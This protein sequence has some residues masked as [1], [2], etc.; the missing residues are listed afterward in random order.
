[1]SRAQNRPR[2]RPRSEEAKQAILRAARELLAR[3]GPGAVTMEAVA[4]L[5]G[6]GKP[7][8]YRWWPDRHA[9]A[10]AALMETT[11][12]AEQAKTRRS[13]ITELRDQ[14]RA[15]AARFATQTGRH[16]ASMLAAA[17]SASE[18]SKAFRNHFVLARRAEGKLLL[19][20]AVAADLVRDDLDL[21]VALDML[22]GPVFFRL[23]LGHAPLDE[24]FM[25]DVLDEAMRGMAVRR[26]PRKR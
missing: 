21:E 1:M 16:V 6:V 22:Y 14:L 12:D 8:V 25:D 2:G 17:D 9:V 18:L 4:E 15:I 3:G 7:T 10:M 5:A 23:L 24:R 13:P 11:V 26:A 19:E 20:R